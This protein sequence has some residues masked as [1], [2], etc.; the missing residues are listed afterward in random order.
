MQVGD[1]VRDRRPVRLTGVH[2]RG[3]ARVQGDPGNP[4]IRG[5]P[6]GVPVGQVVLVDPHAHLDRD[7][8]TIGIVDRRT[9]DR[10]EQIQLPRQRRATSAPRDLGHRTPHVQVDVVGHVLAGDDSHRLGHHGWIDAIQLDGPRGLVGLERAHGQRVRVA[11]DQ[12]ARCHHLTDVQSG[13]I[14]PAQPAKGTVGDSRH[15]REDHWDIDG[16]VADDQRAQHAGRRC[17]SHD[18]TASIPIRS[19]T[20]ESRSRTVTASSS[21]V[22]KST[23][24]QYGVPISSC[25][26]YRRP[27]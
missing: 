6:G 17:T 1:Q 19:W 14:L 13:P 18:S 10:T 15:R 12:R 20:I 7:R 24:M 11:F 9:H 25:R 21:R 22:S 16:G 26:R 5:D 23:V 2:L 4:L 27:I 8:P 3:G